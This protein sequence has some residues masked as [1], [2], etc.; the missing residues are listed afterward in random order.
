MKGI[1]SVH[2]EGELRPASIKFKPKSGVNG[3]TGQSWNASCDPG[4]S[5]GSVVVLN[6]E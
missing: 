5:S 4:Y 1:E 6:V 2:E 3:I